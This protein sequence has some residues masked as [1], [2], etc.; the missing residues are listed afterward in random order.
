MIIA[1]G[2]LARVKLP[3]VPGITSFKGDAFHTARWKYSITGGD[4]TGNLDKLKDKV[5]GIIGTGATA[6]Q[7][8]PPLAE[9]AKHLY[10]FQ[11]TPSSIDVRNNR[12]TDETWW[13]SLKPGWQR[14]RMENF[15][16][17]IGGVLPA[18]DLVDD[19]CEF[20]VHKTFLLL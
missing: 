11:R 16:S 17:I 19:G 3:G 18:V 2:L 12:P 10:V 15:T 8:I 5:V 1:S 6:V 20:F 7:C 4:P 9:S 13:Q 14:E